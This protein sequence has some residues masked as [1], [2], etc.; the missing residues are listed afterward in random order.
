MRHKY[1][2][3]IN[4]TQAVLFGDSLKDTVL[5]IT[6]L[7]SLIRLINKSTVSYPRYYCANFTVFQKVN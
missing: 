6:L 7:F 1:E 3:N 4:G 5:E 2:V